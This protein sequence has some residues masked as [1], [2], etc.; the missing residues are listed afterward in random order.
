MSIITLRIMLGKRFTEK[1]LVLPAV[2]SGAKQLE[3]LILDIACYWYDAHLL[4]W[5][6]L[7]RLPRL[8][9]LTVIQGIQLINESDGGFA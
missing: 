9:V 3:I 1:H 2:M 8:R 7:S 6:E 4:T 5:W